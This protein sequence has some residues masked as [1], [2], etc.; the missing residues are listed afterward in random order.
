MTEENQV[1][2]PAIS[3]V[4]DRCCGCGACA[5]VCPVGCLTLEQDDLGFVRSKYESGC[6]SCGLCGQACPVLTVGDG[7][8]AISAEWAK[9]KDDCERERSSSGGVFGLLAQH[10]LASGGTV[11]GAAFSDS[12]KVV[13]HIRVDN[14]AKLGAVMRSKYVQSTLGIDTYKALEADL[15]AGREALFSGTACQCAGVRNYLSAKRV[16]MEALL[17]VEVICHGV[18][19]PRLWTEWLEWV[20]FRT[21]AEIDGVN[22]RSKSTGWLTYSVAYSESTEKV[23]CQSVSQDWYMRAFL[24]NASLRHSCLDCPAKRSCGSDLTL[25]DFWGIQST[26]PEA[27]DRLGVSAVICNTEKGRAAL[28]AVRGQLTSG[29]S[30]IDEIIPSNPALMYSAEPHPKRREFLMDVAEGKCIQD[31]MAKWTFEPSLS[32]K[33]RGKLG[34][35]KRRIEKILE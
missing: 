2:E 6:I 35:F 8:R 11:Y 25:G 1:S 18:P 33:I 9:A 7:D 5:A 30:S 32:Q 19:A 16:P 26:H 28:N 21:E 15:R 31:L 27:L 3:I 4:G 22:F 17:L 34:H 23:R 10:V 24:Q 14:D 20:S 13:H 12:C 29:A